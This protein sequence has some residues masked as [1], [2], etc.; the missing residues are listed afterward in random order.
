MGR[1]KDTYG[2]IQPGE[3]A[4]EARGR[5]WEVCGRNDHGLRVYVGVDI[6]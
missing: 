3:G 4:R 1:K 6:H 2:K 5:L